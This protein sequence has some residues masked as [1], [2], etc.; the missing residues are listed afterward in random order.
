MEWLSKI[1]LKIA[2]NTCKDKFENVYFTNENCTTSMAT[3]S[4]CGVKNYGIW[5]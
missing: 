1:A 4:K 5:G 2:V 3:C